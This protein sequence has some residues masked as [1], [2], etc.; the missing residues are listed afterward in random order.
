MPVSETSVKRPSGWL[1]RLLRIWTLITLATFA[2][3]L[4]HHSDSPTVLGRYSTLVG[5]LLA[6]LLALAILMG[7]WSAWLARHPASLTR[8]DSA[9]GRW[10]QRRAFPFMVLGATSAAII[11]IWLFFLGSHVATYAVLRTFL[12]LTLVV[13]ALALLWG[14]ET[15]LGSLHFPCLPQVGL[16][17]L[18]LVALLTISFYPNLAKTDEAFVLSMARNVMQSGHS[19]PQI[20]AAAYPD[21]YY[22]GVWVNM[23]AAWLKVAGVS[24]TAGRLYNLVLASLS[25]TFIWIATSRLFDKTTAWYAALIGAYAFM[26]LNHIRFDIHAAFWL[27]LGILLFSFNQAGRWGLYWLTGFVVGMSIDSSPVAYCF[28]GGLLLFYAWDYVR[29]IRSERQ[30]MWP[31]FFWTALGSACAF[32]FYLLSHA[33]ASFANDQTTG[34]ML[35]TYPEII[36]SN[37]LEGHFRSQLQQYLTV[38]LTAQPLLFGL[39]LLGIGAGLWERSRNDRFLLTIYFVWMAVIVFAYFYFP[40]FYLMLALPV[41]ITLAA[42][43]L[44]RGLE[45]LL[46]LPEK[47]HPAVTTTA[48]FLLLVC[49][50]ASVAADIRGLGSQSVEDVVQTGHEIAQIIPEDAVIVAAELYYFGMLDHTRFVGGA[51]EGIL[52]NLDKL[53]A[54][55]VWPTVAP[56]AVVFSEGWP[57][58]PERSPNLMTYLTEMNFSLLTCYQ[59]KSFGRIELWTRTIPEGLTPNGDCVPV[60][61]PRTGCG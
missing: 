31:P 21:H 61:N 14:G 22:G 42:R 34:G 19:S 33:G 51:V 47:N 6:G 54:A 5:G 12:I 15:A 57:T 27:S 52:T 60:C 59:T 53:P 24:L 46:S 43:G 55:Q 16:A 30:W 8:I 20:Y 1:L 3:M 38:F 11:G 48:V 35:S 41:F 56:D 28:T 29:A 32:G 9:L 37:L 25:L 26:S 10:R 58:E 7:L 4:T 49:L 2:V 44:S 17:L 13:G 18:L 36:R 45:M 40:V 39:L 50:F 23:M